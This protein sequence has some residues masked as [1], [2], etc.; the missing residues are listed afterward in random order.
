MNFNVYTLRILLLFCCL[1]P[2]TPALANHIITDMTGRQVSIPDQIHH[3][4]AI[5]HCVPIVAAVAP[6]D[7]VTMQPELS[8]TAKH[9]VSPSL[10]TNKVN[11]VGMARLTDE[12][13][14]KLSPDIIVMETK[15]G[16]HDNA[17]RME[18]R[19]HIP[20]VVIDQDITKY[21]ETFSLLG[22]ILNRPGQ[23]N[24]LANFVRTYI[25]P[26]AKKA[27][28]IPTA[29]RVHAYY[30]EGED[31]FSTNLGGTE[32]TQALD[33]VGGIN[34][35]QASILPGEAFVTVSPEQLYIWNPDVILVWSKGAEQL[36]TWRAIVNNPI[37]QGIS[38]VKKGRVVQ[39][40]WLPLSWFD[41]PPGSNRIIGIIWLAQELY[42]EVYH[43][44]LPTITKEYF[45]KFYHTEISDED[46]K[47]LLDMA[48]PGQSRQTARNS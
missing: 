18:Q 26:I 1:V 4:Y 7:L 8:D 14:L 3:V 9:L 11:L 10:Y 45:L 25:D 34:V 44:D 13:I 41:R 2:A 43:F 22:K 37:W 5:G 33:Y 20:V 6:E 28:A 24:I 36:S 38:A 27:G 17:M 42:P 16:P 47:G 29:R 12:E 39:V 35:A 21:K 40:P 32:H 46:V 31:G 30:A 48:H 19:L 15:E 23:G